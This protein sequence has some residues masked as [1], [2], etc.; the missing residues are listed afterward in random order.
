MTP[1]LTIIYIVV[2]TIEFEISPNFLNL[3]RSSL[4]FVSSEYQEQHS[5]GFPPVALFNRSKYRPHHPLR[6][7]GF[8]SRY[9]SGFASK[10][11]RHD[12]AQK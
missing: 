3:I 5:G 8:D 1:L 6:L 10:A 2:K 12:G 4:F 9:L 7:A 11:L